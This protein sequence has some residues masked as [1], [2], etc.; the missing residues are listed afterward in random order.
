M[1]KYSI[2][3]SSTRR[4]ANYS[5]IIKPPI[6][7]PKP[8]NVRIKAIPIVDNST[9]Y[10]LEVT[11]DRPIRP[12]TGIIEPFVTSY[13]IQYSRNGDI[14]GDQREILE[15]G[16]RVIRYENVGTGSFSARVAA[17]IAIN[18]KTS[19]WTYSVDSAVFFP[20]NFTMDYTDPD[21]Y[22]TDP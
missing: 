18:D 11:W 6:I 13:L 14:Y 19:L 15:N 21:N 1:S 20:I 12:I 16:S 9:S 17:K 4:L 2:L 3:E 5:G 10:T 7:A 22:G 8:R